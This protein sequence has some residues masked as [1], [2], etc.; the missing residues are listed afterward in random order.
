MRKNMIA[1]H[2]SFLLDIE[3]KISLENIGNEFFHVFFFLLYHMRALLLSCV[4]PHLFQDTG[5]V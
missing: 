5:Y 3:G 2:C 4:F 1:M